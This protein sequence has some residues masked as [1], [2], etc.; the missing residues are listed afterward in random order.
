MEMALGRM[1][2]DTNPN[3]TRSKK[4]TLCRNSRRDGV[5]GTLKA[6]KARVPLGVDLAAIMGL[7]HLTQDA[8]VLRTQVTVRGTVPP[9]KLRRAL[10]IAE[11]AVPF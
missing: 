1:Q 5:A 7:K 3:H 9:R 11:W 8:A 4:G 6:N 10:D 2:A